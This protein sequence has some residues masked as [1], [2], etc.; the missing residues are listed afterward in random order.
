MSITTVC[1]NIGV[2]SQPFR[3]LIFIE[4]IDESHHGG[5]VRCSCRDTLAEGVHGKADREDSPIYCRVAPERE[6]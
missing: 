4:R 6:A 5:L 1:Q 3:W 2:V